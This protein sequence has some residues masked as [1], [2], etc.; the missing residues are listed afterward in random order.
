MVEDLLAGR[1]II[2]SHQTVRALAEMFGRELAKAIRHRLAGKLGDK[3][4]LDEVVIEGRKHWL[5]QAVDQEGARWMCWVKPAA[6]GGPGSVANVPRLPVG[7]ALTH[8]IIASSGVSR[9][10]YAWFQGLPF[11]C[12]YLGRDQNRPYDT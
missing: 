7:A 5:R 10:A 11:S 12:S 8:R 4:H 1:G 2:V 9:A 6:I 3:W